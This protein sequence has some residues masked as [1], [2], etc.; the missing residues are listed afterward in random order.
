[1]GVVN[2]HPASGGPLIYDNT[3]YTDLT[4]IQVHERNEAARLES[5]SDGPLIEEIT[6]LDQ[7]RAEYINND[8]KLFVKQIDYLWRQ[9][10]QIRK[11]KGDGS[12]FYRSMA[13]AYVERL[14]EHPER[15]GQSLDTLEALLR[16]I[17]SNNL[18]PDAREYYEPLQSL[19]ESI[20]PYCATGR[21]LTPELLLRKFQSEDSNWIVFFFRLITSARICEDQSLWGFLDGQSPSDFCQAQVLLPGVEADHIQA[22]ALCRALN[23]KTQIAN[24][25]G[26]FH[27]G[28][29]IAF[30]LLGK[31]NESAITLLFRPGHYDILIKHR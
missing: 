17:V 16:Q 25:D 4:P 22:E 30:T 6:P 29:P 26:E 15:V 2:V 8:N 11:T 10:Y 21:P 7:L 19:I 31:G 24:L 20:E 18:Y 27:A 13:F 1:L 12:C 9:G 5:M 14:L 28:D 3:A 23:V